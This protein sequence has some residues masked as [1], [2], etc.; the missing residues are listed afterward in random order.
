MSSLEI[1]ARQAIESSWFK[2]W[3]INVESIKE[4]DKEIIFLKGETNSFFVKQMAQET[5]MAVMRKKNIGRV[6]LQNRIKVH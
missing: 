6:D 4:N 2:H 5:V 1:E 3:G